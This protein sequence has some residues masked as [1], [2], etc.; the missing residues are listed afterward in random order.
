MHTYQLHYLAFLWTFFCSLF[1]S[2]CVIWVL[3]VY[4][5]PSFYLFMH[6]CSCATVNVFL[7]VWSRLC[8]WLRILMMNMFPNTI[9]WKQLIYKDA[10][11]CSYWSFLNK[12]IYFNNIP[13][14]DHFWM[15]TS[16]KSFFLFLFLSLQLIIWK[17]KVFNH[18]YM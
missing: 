10:L 8:F 5:S 2:P 18:K 16:C 11:I 13:L 7:G 14:N 15:R 9:K 4:F 12:N 3:G 17:L 6:L 1:L